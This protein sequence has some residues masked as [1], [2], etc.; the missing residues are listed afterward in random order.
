MSNNL[1]KK[2]KETQKR[3]QHFEELSKYRNIDFPNNLTII[4]KNNLEE[5]NKYFFEKIHNNIDYE[6]KFDYDLLT[7]IYNYVA[8]LKSYLN[9]KKR[10]IETRC[11]SVDKAELTSIFEKYW[12][13]NRNKT[14]LDKLITIRDRMEHDTLT[15]GIKLETCF[16]QECFER[17]LVVD[18]IDIIELSNKGYEELISLGR[19][20]ENFV[21]KRLTELNL[22]DCCLFM[23]AF[24]RFFNKPPYTQLFPEETIDEKNY[25]DNL[26]KA[27][28]ND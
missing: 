21:E 23:N 11:K 13:A 24:N 22:R 12:K 20:I 17:K 1:E 7:A 3:L 15:T 19:D 25:Y 28:K 4:C 5:L 8:S 10:A 16:Y 18:N 14:I 6:I 26:I 9:R 27:L 2:R